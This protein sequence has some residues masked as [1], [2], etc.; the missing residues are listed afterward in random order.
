[1]RGRKNSG[2]PKDVEVLEQLEEVSLLSDLDVTVTIS[3]ANLR[4]LVNKAGNWVRRSDE[5]GMRTMWQGAENA[6]VD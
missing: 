4:W 5:D 1:M 6:E 2:K 3:T